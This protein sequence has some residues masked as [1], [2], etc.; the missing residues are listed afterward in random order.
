MNWPAISPDGSS[1]AVD[2]RD[3]QTG[4][5]DLWLHDLTRGTASR[6]TFTSWTSRYPVWSPDGSR[7]AFSSSREGRL[8]LYQ[9]ATSGSFQEDMLDKARQVLPQDWS[10][11]GRF[12]IEQV[13]DPKTGFDVWVLPLFGDRKPFPYLQT[14][15]SERF[16]KLSPN[17][18]W[19]AYSSDETKRTE[20]YVSDLSRAWRKMASLHEWRHSSRLEPGWQTTLLHRCGSKN[21]GGRGEEP[22]RQI[23]G[24]RSENS[25]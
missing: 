4:L 23:R 14:A 5:N 10:R 21:D 7:L 15:F 24:R 6:F 11:D 25:L 3:P 13:I 17:G 1:V 22:R 18:E 16:A 2:W 20:V 19:L 9:K 8:T 12:L